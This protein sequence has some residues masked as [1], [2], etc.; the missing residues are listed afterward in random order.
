MDSAFRSHHVYK[1][2]QS[3]VIGEQL[4]LKSLPANPNNK[5]AVCDS[6]KGFSDSWPH[7]IGNLFTGH[8]VLYYTKGLCRLRGRLLSGICHITG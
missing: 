5:F 2:V 6:D 8:V 3:P 7:Y 1:S 4:V